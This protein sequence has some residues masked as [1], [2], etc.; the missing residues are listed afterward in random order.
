MA[1]R[2]SDLIR[3]WKDFSFPARFREHRLFQKS[4]KRNIFQNWNFA[5]S[6]PQEFYTESSPE[7]TRGKM[8]GFL[9]KITKH[10]I[11]IRVPYSEPELRGLRNSGKVSI[12]LMTCKPDDSEVLQ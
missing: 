3:S 11:G 12:R 8:P 6:I 10:Q 5:T 2:E 7:W 4:G 9:L 1:F